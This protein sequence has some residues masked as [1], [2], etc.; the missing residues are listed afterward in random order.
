MTRVIGDYPLAMTD[1][2]QAWI[3]ALIGAAAD[4]WLEIPRLANGDGNRSAR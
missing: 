4:R 3:R 1:I 2:D